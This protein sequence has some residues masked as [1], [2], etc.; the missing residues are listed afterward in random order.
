MIL[1]FSDTTFEN[2]Y[3]EFC[4]NSDQFINLP[5]MHVG[6]RS[7]IVSSTIECFEP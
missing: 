1:S 7:Y 5:I 4:I 3:R 6:R 2:T